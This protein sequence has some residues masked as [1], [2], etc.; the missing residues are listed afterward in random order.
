MTYPKHDHEYAEVTAQTQAPNKNDGAEREF[1]S[2]SQCG[3]CGKAETN[4]PDEAPSV[5]T[6]VYKGEDPS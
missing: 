2:W 4:R 1:I 3:V 5:K 6:T